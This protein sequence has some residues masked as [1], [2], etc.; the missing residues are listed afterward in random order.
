MGDILEVVMVGHI[1][2]MAVVLEGLVLRVVLPVGVWAVLSGRTVNHMHTR[3]ALSHGHAF[4]KWETETKTLTC[5]KQV[6]ERQVPY[7]S[8][9][10]YSS[11]AFSQ[12]TL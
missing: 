6:P 7:N 2:D 3:R 5:G 11:T 9:E 10:P 1:I 8:L 12:A 4:I